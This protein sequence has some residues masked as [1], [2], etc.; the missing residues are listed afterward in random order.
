M[1]WKF[2][3]PTTQESADQNYAL[4]TIFIPVTSMETK[5]NSGPIQNLNLG[6]LAPYAKII[7]LDQRAPGNS[8][9]IN[10]IR[11]STCPLLMRS[12]IPNSAVM[13]P[14]WSSGQDT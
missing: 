10:L 14:L 5:K 11:G 13:L 6:H 3:G 7:L 4:L 2:A 9:R 1:Q 8:V 12:H